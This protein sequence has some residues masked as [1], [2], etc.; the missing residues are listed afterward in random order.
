MDAAALKSSDPFRIEYVLPGID[1][2]GWPE[3]F[4]R[5]LDVVTDPGRAPHVVDGVLI[6]GIVAHQP[7]G[8]LRPGIDQ[9]RQHRLI[10]LLKNSGH[11]L[12]GEKIPG[13]HH[14]IVAG[15]ASQ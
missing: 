10:E 5:V 9:V 7:I 11:D 3:D 8:D 14:D 4:V 2:R 12:P 6:A 13:R 1:R 15:F